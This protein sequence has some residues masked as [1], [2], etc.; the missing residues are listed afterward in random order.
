MLANILALAVGLGSLALYMAAFFFPEVHR[1]NDFLWSGVGF[2]YALV[3][4]FCA[5]QITGLI[6]LGQVACVA[7]LGWLGWQMLVLRRSLTPTDLQTPVSVESLTQTTT[8]TCTQ[9]KTKLRD[10]SLLKS[11]PTLAIRLKTLLQGGFINSTQNRTNPRA[12]S[13]AVSQ[14]KLNR[15]FEYEFIEDGLRNRSVHAAVSANLEKAPPTRAMAGPETMDLSKALSPPSPKEDTA[16]GLSPVEDSPDQG[17]NMPESMDIAEH[18]IASEATDVL[19]EPPVAAISANI[20]AAKAELS[21]IAEFPQPVAITPESAT[22]NFAHQ[23]LEKTIIIKDW[24]QELIASLTRPKP[25]YSMIELPP[26]PPSIPRPT[27]ELSDLT[28]DEADEFEAAFAELDASEKKELDI[29]ETAES[30][31]EESL[32]AE[33]A[34]DVEDPDAGLE[35]ISGGDPDIEAAAIEASMRIDSDK[36]MESSVDAELLGDSAVNETGE[37]V[38]R[39]SS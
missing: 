14:R 39:I 18:S 17:I 37:L 27:A 23:T 22:K 5:R 12:R 30:G 6:L 11:I 19:S 9:V 16:A 2:F 38:N 35:E 8:Q 3:L 20:N 1:K 24:I 21:G 13:R 33:I 28:V 25:K 4:W 34:D 7:L 31:L 32:S 29:I 10:G 36:R 26:R 15:R